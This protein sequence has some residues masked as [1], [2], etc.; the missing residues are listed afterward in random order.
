MGIAVHPST[1][2]QTV[3]LIPQA[4]TRA[5]L[6]HPGFAATPIVTQ[7]PVPSHSQLAVLDTQYSS[8]GGS[9][10]HIVTSHLLPSAAGLPHSHHAY[11]SA[12]LHHHA[13]SINLV[14]ALTQVGRLIILSFTKYF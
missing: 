10:H 4:V 9:S 5:P 11:A 3:T 12:P 14:S 2:P 1:I 8:T 7:S 6:L 13:G